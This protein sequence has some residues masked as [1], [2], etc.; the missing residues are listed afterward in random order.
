MTIDEPPPG[1]PQLVVEVT[2][3]S[4]REVTFSYEFDQPQATSGGGGGSMPACTTTVQGWGEIG[5]RYQLMINGVSTV[6]GSLP[7]GAGAGSFLYVR[8]R[9]DPDGETVAGQSGL[10]RQEPELISEPIEGCG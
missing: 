7:P 3:R 10:V 5:G 4:D 9:V 1:G 2:N 8:L 6:Q